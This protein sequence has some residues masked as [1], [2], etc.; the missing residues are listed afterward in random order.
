MHRKLTLALTFAAAGLTAGT[1]QAATWTVGSQTLTPDLVVG[2]GTSS[3]LLAIDPNLS[4]DPADTFLIEY[5]WDGS[6]LTAS[7]LLNTIEADTG[8]IDAV[9]HPNFIDTAMF[10]LGVDVDGDGLNLTTGTPAD[11][12]GSA[13]TENGVSNDADD[14]YFEGWFTGFWGHTT[15]PDGS[16]WTSSG[17]LAT[18][19]LANGGWQGLSWAP[20]FATTDPTVVP[21]PASLALLGLGGLMLAGRRRR[22]M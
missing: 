20:G 6:A 7:D 8:R 9:W 16:T 3:T 10:G 4:T 17:G 2:T 1:M 12:S 18:V 11:I 13:T 19:T 5:N 22:Q 14:F 15:S 21:E